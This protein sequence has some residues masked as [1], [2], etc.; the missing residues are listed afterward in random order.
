MGGVRV[1]GLKK[2]YPGT[3]EPAV[4]N[5]QFGIQRSECFGMLGS[6]GAGKT[7]TIHIL[8]GLHAPSGGTALV[9]EPGAA[10][11]DIRTQMGRVQSAMGVCPQA[12]VTS[13]ARKSPPAQHA[14]HVSCKTG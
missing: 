6:N 7:T 13:P 5:V 3:K 10:E 12:L 14:N 8:C 2:Q 4:K 11:L 9:G 1:L